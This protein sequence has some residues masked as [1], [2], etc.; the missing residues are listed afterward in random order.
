MRVLHTSD[1]HLGQKFLYND[2][3]TEH[4]LALEWLRGCIETHAVDV[5]I[6]SG[7]VFDTG[8]PPNYA[9][10]LYYRFLTGLLGTSCRN[11][12]ITGGNHDSP[13]TLDAPR[14]LLQA[15][16]IQVMGA[17]PENP[18]DAFLLL[19]D[20]SGQPLAV[21]AAVP[22]L[23]DRDLRQ[24]GSTPGSF[25][26]IAR[27][28][29]GILRHYQQLATAAQPYRQYD[30]PIIATGHLYASGAT[31]SEKQDN[32]YLGDVANIEAEQFPDIFDYIALGHIHRA[33]AIGNRTHIRYSG[34][35]LPLSFSET[36]DDKIV[37]LLDFEGSKLKNIEEV[38]VP[39]FRRLKTIQGDLESVKASLQRFAARPH[40]DLTP[41]VELLVET[42]QYIPQMDVQ[43]REFA[44]DMP[45]ELLKVKIIRTLTGESETAYNEELSLEDLEVSD[46][47]KKRCEQ[48][49]IPE[50]E[51]GELM[52]TFLELRQWMQDKQET[53]LNQPAP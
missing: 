24:G 18:E 31:G 2:R 15:L 6:V 49:L 10:Q 22:F 30:I 23:R 34:S 45:L 26:R 37:Y 21:V 50:A 46:V 44:A 3:E 29:E 11:I 4:R 17:A 16:N 36:K 12:V 47:F 19:K 38:A 48:F 41:W 42:D 28:R 1:W 8:N 13:S 39:V 40:G 20:Q 27:L 53:T 32:I 35:L 5:L 14:E 51:A 33:Q 25:D 7:D 9:L 52:Q 43:L